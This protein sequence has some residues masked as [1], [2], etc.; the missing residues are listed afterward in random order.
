MVPGRF[1]L[2][3]ARGVKWTQGTWRPLNLETNITRICAECPYTHRINPLL[4]CHGADALAVHVHHITGGMCPA[5]GQHSSHISS[6][7]AHYGTKWLG[8][9][10][11]LSV[12]NT[13]VRP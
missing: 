4:T 9:C 11:H 2:Y 1:I 6:L 12:C 3:G 5:G 7:I 13:S 8:C 10:L